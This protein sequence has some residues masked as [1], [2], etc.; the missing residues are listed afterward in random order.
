M[1][2][3]TFGSIWTCDSMW[4]VGSSRLTPLVI[5]TLAVPTLTRLR[6][7]SVSWKCYSALSLAVEFLKK[8]DHICSTS[9]IQGSCLIG[10]GGARSENFVLVLSRKHH[11]KTW[12]R[13][14][15]C[16]VAGQVRILRLYFWQNLMEGSDDGLDHRAEFTLVYTSSITRQTH[17]F[18]TDHLL[19]SNIKHIH[20]P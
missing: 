1:W 14:S 3:W 4:E 13:P 2:E 6:A 19:T 15:Q 17:I 16:C 12:P 7:V 5:Y 11:R 20:G 9:K 8:H 18:S 10:K